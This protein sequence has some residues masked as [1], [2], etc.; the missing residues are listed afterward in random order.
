MH[1]LCAQAKGRY[2]ASALVRAEKAV[3]RTALIKL[4]YQLV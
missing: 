3:D 2:Y 4:V 1:G